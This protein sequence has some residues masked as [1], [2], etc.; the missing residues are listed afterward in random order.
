MSAIKKYTIWLTGLPASGKTT[1]AKSITDAYPN[2]FFIDS[3]E[4]SIII[5]PSSSFSQKERLC[6]Y[7]GMIYSASCLNNCGINVIIAATGN[8]RRFSEHARKNIENFI[9]IYVKCSVETCMQRDP[10]G[11]YKKAKNGEISTLPLLIE[12]FNDDF[13]KEYFPLFDVYEPPLSA[14]LI[15]NTDNLTLKE[16]TDLLVDFLES[17]KVL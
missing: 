1:L 7:N 3:E 6:V 15:I 5:T 11:F 2:I 4:A 9:E 8:Y 12:G 13:V 16:S 10:K 14:D 17:K